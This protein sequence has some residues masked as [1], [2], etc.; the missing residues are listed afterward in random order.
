ML[1][2]VFGDIV[3]SAYEWHNVKHKNFDLVTPRTR[4][5]DDS[6]MT[7]ANAWWLT[8]DPSH[9]PEQ[10]VRCMHT[11]GR[12]HSGVGYGGNFRRWLFNESFEPY[13]SWG[14][15]SAMRVSPIGL[16]AKSIDEVLELARISASVTHNHREG[17]KGAQATALAV[18]L[19]HTHGDDPDIREIIKHE[20]STRFGYYLDRT[21]DN[22]RP[23]YEFDVSCQGSVPEAIIAYLESDTLEDC[24]RGAISIGGDSDTIAA[25]ACGIHAAHPDPASEALMAQFEHYLTP[26]LLQIQSDFEQMIAE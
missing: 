26:D 15:G 11:L 24:V 18:F 19:S 8:I 14:N 25:I 9:S 21:L 6:V 22:I 20:V 23:S 3:G 12:R 1:G 2:A 16:Y 10:L 13:N 5:T 7:L 17:I 4:F